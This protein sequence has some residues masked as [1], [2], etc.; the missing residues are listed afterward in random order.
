LGEK[1][2]E[3]EKKKLRSSLFS[4][5]DYA[6][7]P[8]VSTQPIHLDSNDA[9]G[10]DGYTAPPAKRAKLPAPA[11]TGTRKE[12]YYYSDEEEE[13]QNE[14]E[15]DADSTGAAGNAEESNK[16]D[17]QDANG[18]NGSGENHEDEN[19]E[20]G[21]DEYVAFVA[22]LKTDHMCSCCV[23]KPLLFTYCSKMAVDD[24]PPEPVKPA[25]KGS[26]H[27]ELRVPHAATTY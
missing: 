25:M 22:L 10:D 27:S 11:A 26:Y 14:D 6:S 20:E 4:S 1:E 17:Q 3:K 5:Q 9:D 7:Q 21:D 18:E 8:S 15:A 16:S 19:D 12:G 24:T 23:A 13:E 2:K